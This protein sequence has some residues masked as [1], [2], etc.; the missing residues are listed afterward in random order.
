MR[1]QPLLAQHTQLKQTAS[2]NLSMI[3]IIIKIIRHKLGMY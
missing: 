3:S 2:I 1:R